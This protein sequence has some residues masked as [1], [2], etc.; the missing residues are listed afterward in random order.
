MRNIDAVCWSTDNR[1]IV[2]GSRDSNIRLWRSSA[3]N[4]DKILTPREEA[5]RNYANALK[6]Q[7]SSHPAVKKI[8]KFRHVPKLIHNEKKHLEI[9]R[10]ADKK[11]A[12]NRFKNK[13]ES[14]LASEK[15]SHVE[16]VKE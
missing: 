3:S 10:R 11:K 1:Y 15:E 9:M 2:S 14:K 8:V 13:Q 5:S 16:E 12:F 7:Y 6:D 4:S